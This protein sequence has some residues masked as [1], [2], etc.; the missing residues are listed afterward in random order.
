[1]KRKLLGK[2]RKKNRYQV[3]PGNGFLRILLLLRHHQ[4]LA[5][6]VND[7]DKKEQ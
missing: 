4:A 6:E 3:W 7:L 2:S 1:M 5:S